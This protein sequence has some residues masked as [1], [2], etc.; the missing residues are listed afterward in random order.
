MIRNA[1]VLFLS[2]AL[3]EKLLLVAF[4]TIGVL[5]WA[6]SFTGR[7]TAFWQAQRVTT[8]RLKANAEV[9]RNKVIIEETARK[10]ASAL[11]PAQTLNGNKLVTTISQIA[12]DAGLKNIITNGSTVST[13]SGQFAVHSQEFTIRNIEGLQGWEALSRFYEVIQRRSPY[14]AIERFTLL[15]AANNAA[16]LSL[17]LKIASVEITR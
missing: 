2:C 6:S 7:A 3:R 1:R 8:V 5:W 15:S 9:I 13:T 11:D 14:I 16:Q 17:N 12:T 10:T 4:F